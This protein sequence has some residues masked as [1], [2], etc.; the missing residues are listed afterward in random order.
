SS[1]SWPESMTWGSR[2]AIDGV[3]LGQ[4]G[5]VDVGN[6]YEVDLGQF[7]SG[8][9][10][11]SLAIDSTSG[12][13][14]KWGTRED[15]AHPPQLLVDVK[16]GTQIYDGLSQVAA[17]TVGSSDPTY[18]PINHRI[19]VTA[20]GRTLVV[21]GRHADGVQL[22]WR[23]RFGTG[24]H[25]QTTGAVSDGRLLSGT[26]TGD[27]P[28]SIATARDS[29]GDQHAWVVWGR[30]SYTYLKPVQM[31]RLSDLDDPAGPRVGPTVTVDAAPMGAYRPD[32]GF[33]SGPG[34]VRRGAVVWSRCREDSVCELHAAWFTDLDSNTPALHDESVLTSASTYKRWGTLVRTAAGM[35]V[36]ARGPSGKLTIYSHDVSDS[37]G[38]WTPGPPGVEVDDDGPAAVALDSGEVIAATETDAT[39]HVV[40]VQRFSASGAPAPPEL[41]LT[42]YVQ[43]TLTTDGTSAWLVMI[44]KSEGYVVS[45]RLVPGSG[46]STADRVEIGAEGGGNYAWPN[47]VRRVS[48]RLRFVVRGPAGSTTRS[49]VLALQRP[50]P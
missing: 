34:G 9:G 24:W 1:N 35:R 39:N 48:A 22:A 13:G 32:I 29:A 43:P 49:A 40:T 18:L 12:D 3:L 38:S 10:T 45:R 37:L 5:A 46:W 14:A 47:A 31:V 30:K 21:H 27:W 28:A 17:P 26:G 4:F 16:M 7:P 41:R 15:S 19:A 50:L 42:G 8:D 36:A 23:D 33:E 25:N 2:P 11:V 20:G 44:R 6:W